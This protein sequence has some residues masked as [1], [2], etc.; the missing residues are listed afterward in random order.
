MRALLRGVAGSRIGS[1]IGSAVALGIL[2]VAGAA[3]ADFLV[4][5]FEQDGFVLEASDNDSDFVNHLSPKYFDGLRQVFLQGHGELVSTVT[6]APGPGDDALVLTTG[7]GARV[8]LT[9]GGGTPKADFS[10]FAAFEV[11]VT[12]APSGGQLGVGFSNPE[13]HASADAV[14]DGPGL[15]RFEFADMKTTGGFD[16]TAVDRINA[17]I[18]ATG[19]F[20]QTFAISEIRI[21]PEAEASGVALGT[22]LG[23]AAFLRRRAIA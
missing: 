16:F 19:S 5:D 10:G 7:S 17:S 8:Y 9:Y 20:G 2:I 23:A 6:L 1:A 18:I 21:V 11:E 4:D 14:F 12:A 13:G 15:Y 22:L 3:G